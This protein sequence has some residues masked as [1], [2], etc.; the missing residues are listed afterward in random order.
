[1]QA[2][3]EQHGRGSGPFPQVFEGIEETAQ[4]GLSRDRQCAD[5]GGPDHKPGIGAQ[6]MTIE[7]NIAFSGLRSKFG[8]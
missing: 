6:A 7:T 8:A 2:L 5:T 1:V 3:A 4:I